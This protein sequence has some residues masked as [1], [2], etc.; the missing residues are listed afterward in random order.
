MLLYGSY[1][2][3]RH[4]DMA[5]TNKVNVA[6]ML[7]LEQDLQRRTNR[8]ALFCFFHSIVLVVTW[9]LQS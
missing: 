4:K 2:S 5:E 8:V 7:Q 3:E 6:T 9:L 1:A